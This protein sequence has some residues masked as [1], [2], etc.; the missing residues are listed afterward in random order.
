[1]SIED[2]KTRLMA[3]KDVLNH[4]EG[5]NKALDEL[6]RL[7]IIVLSMVAA[8]LGGY[9]AYIIIYVVTA[10]FLATQLQDWGVII[11]IALLII[12]PYYVYTRIDKLMREVSTYNY[13]T[14]N[15]SKAFLEFSRYCQRWIL[16]VL[17][18]R[19]IGLGLVMPC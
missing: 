4:I 16:I 7:L 1:M 18:I 19:S 17:S 5:I 10:H 15:F 12:V 3:L 14:E 6:P 9:I 8:V 13:W 11:T 2:A